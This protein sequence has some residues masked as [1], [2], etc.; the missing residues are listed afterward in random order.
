MSTSEGSD[1][2]AGKSEGSQKSIIRG[3][4]VDPITG[5]RREFEKTFEG[6]R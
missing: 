4:G 1:A 6:W 2:S 5:Q 3:G